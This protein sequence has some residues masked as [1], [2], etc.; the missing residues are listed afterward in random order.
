MQVPEEIGAGIVG[1]LGSHCVRFCQITP[2]SIRVVSHC[3]LREQTVQ[4]VRRARLL[5]QKRAF[6]A[7]RFQSCW[8]ACKR[9][10]LASSLLLGTV[11]AIALATP[12]QTGVEQWSPRMLPSV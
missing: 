12:Y 10:R 8:L 9:C 3:S 5:L 2:A 4:G 11:S 6:A 7:T 1:R